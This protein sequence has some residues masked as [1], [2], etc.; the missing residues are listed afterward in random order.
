[1]K[2]NTAKQ[3]VFKE[4]TTLKNIIGT[5]P[6]DREVIIKSGQQWQIEDDDGIFKNFHLDKD[7]NIVIGDLTSDAME[8]IKN[9]P[10]GMS[11]LMMM[12]QKQSL[13]VR[14]K[15]TTQTKVNR[16]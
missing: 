7:S 8:E 14:M 5:P 16:L 6:T 4:K 2:D 13:Q 12:I 11:Q 9:S 1:M 3:I 15:R 10:T